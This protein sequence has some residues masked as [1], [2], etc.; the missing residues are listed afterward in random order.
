MNM[1]GFGIFV[2]VISLAWVIF[3]VQ[4]LLDVR[5]ELR[6]VNLNLLHLIEAIDEQAK[7]SGS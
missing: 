3:L 1:E 6:Q 4:W 2:L 7:E 5:R